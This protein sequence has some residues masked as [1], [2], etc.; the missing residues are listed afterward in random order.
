MSLDAGTLIGVFG[1]LLGVVVGAGFQ[2]VQ[3]KRTH[4]WQAR[5][6]DRSQLQH[7]SA[8]YLAATWRLA[9][10]LDDMQ[11]LVGP[12]DQE[13]VARLQELYDSMVEA[14]SVLDLLCNEAVYE[15]TKTYSWKLTEATERARGGALSKDTTVTLACMEDRRNLMNAIRLQL[16]RPPILKR[17]ETSA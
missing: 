13:A 17:R 12:P 11:P 16:G 3:S 5:D 4:A 14:R 15:F 10:T 2:L 8:A 6:A 1:A 9:S 7:Y